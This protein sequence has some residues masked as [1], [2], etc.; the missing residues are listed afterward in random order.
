MKK[1]LLFIF[2]C[3]VCNVNGWGQVKHSVKIYPNSKFVGITKTNDK[4]AVQKLSDGIVLGNK[5][6]KGII[7]RAYLEFDL[8]GKIP[9]D[10]VIKLVE[11]KLTA[12]KD[13]P[14]DKFG[15]K[16]RLERTGNFINDANPTTWGF[17]KT[18]G[19][20]GDYS[21][22]E[23]SFENPSVTHFLFDYLITQ[24]VKENIGGKV[25][26]IINNKNET[27]NKYVHLSGSSEDLYLLV[28]YESE[29]PPTPP[30]YWHGIVAPH[31]VEH[32]QE[33]WFNIYLNK[34]MILDD[35]IKGWMYDPNIFEDK[36][37]VPHCLKLK[38]KYVNGVIS[39]NI[40]VL[41][42][43]GER[44]DF[45]VYI[46]GE[47]KPQHTGEK[48]ICSL[49]TTA[50]YEIPGLSLLNEFDN[51]YCEIN[52]TYSNNMTLLSGQGQGEV[53]FRIDNTGATVVRALIKI[54]DT[55]TMFENPFYKEYTV[56][57]SDVWVGKPKIDG[58]DIIQHRDPITT[59]LNYN[60]LYFLK[61]KTEEKTTLS[62]YR[63]TLSNTQYATILHGRDTYDMIKDVELRTGHVAANDIKHTIITVDARNVCGTT[64]FKRG[65]WIAGPTSS[66]GGGGGGWPQE[67]NPG[68]DPLSLKSAT[69]VSSPLSIRVF[70]FTTGTLVH[71]EK[72][73][74]DFNIQNTALK[75]GIYVIETTDKDGKKTTE[76]IF[77]KNK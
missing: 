41:L 71:Q 75:E 20:T 51:N 47:L 12:K 54:K 70:N 36:G 66:G 50:S 44:F 68:I 76:K 59:D 32:Q 57:N 40:A 55:N 14:S 63:W 9:N 22:V 25:K 72:N 26:F 52:W 6:G 18:L 17:L 11:I 74:M 56:Q 31:I 28:E 77:K 21:G 65:I 33:I 19:M 23:A 24:H 38:S 62:E 35:E 8:E 13:I 5:E 3:C 34:R 69:P 27:T 37:S 53:K 7:G 10:A 64:T 4:Y 73:V 15:G 16:I 46:I 29:T 61:L 43:S 58:L 2:I 1:I 60:T 48:I 67:P 30:L 39:E 42:N 45:K 49:G